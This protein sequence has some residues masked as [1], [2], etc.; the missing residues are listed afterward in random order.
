MTDTK[1]NIEIIIVEDDKMQQD[2]YKDCIEE[3]NISNEKYMITV[4][5]LD[6]DVEIPSILYNNHIDAIIVDLNW[7]A[8][9]TEN[10][11][12]DLISKIYKDCR[13]PIFVIS[14]NLQYLTSEYIESPIFKKYQ[15]DDIEFDLVLKEIENIYDTGY[16]RVLGSNSKIDHMLSRVFWEYMTDTID[17]WKEQ[18][19]EILTQRMLRYATTRIN[20]M[21]MI[22]SLQNHDD[23][24]SIEFYIKPAIKNQPFTGDI[25]S[26]Q[27]KKYVVITAACDIEQ[28]NSEY[29]VLCRISFDIINNLKTRIKEGSNT[30]ENDLIKYINNSKA[31]FHLLPPCNVFSGG[32]VD[33]QMLSSVKKEDFFEH[34]IVVASINPSFV[35]D[36]QAR[37]SHYYGRQ[38]QPQLNKGNIIEFIKNT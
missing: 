8:G 10:K 33:F 2:M 11:G 35:K 19:E 18:Q 26:Y 37:F 22:D 6:N 28:D 14:G 32:L 9:D 7:G 15:R 16:T 23:F 13:I 4:H 3:Y 5:V 25:I 24:D 17:H 1:E 20:E 31:R 30:A 36:I 38:G 12:N 21:L 34:S 29:V 27:E